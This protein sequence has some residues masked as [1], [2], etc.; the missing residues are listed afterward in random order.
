VKLVP[1]SGLAIFFSAYPSP[2]KDLGA[3]EG[4]EMLLSGRPAGI[5][6]FNRKGTLASHP[7]TIR[8]VNVSLQR[9]R[10][11]VAG[12]VPHSRTLA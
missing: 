2:N 10:A 7:K 6:P 4:T 1:E 12:E 11:D 9:M 5:E 8:P 3:I